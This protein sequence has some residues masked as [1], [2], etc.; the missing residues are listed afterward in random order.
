M[1]KSSVS[2]NRNQDPL[3][4][5]MPSSGKRKHGKKD[6]PAGGG[7]CRCILSNQIKNVAIRG[8]V[9]NDNKEQINTI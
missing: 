6:T 4:F 3:V 7:S 9:I 8:I 1:R 5:N 2:K